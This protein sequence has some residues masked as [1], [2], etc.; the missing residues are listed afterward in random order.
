[1]QRI[2]C[3]SQKGGVGKSTLARDIAVQFAA[4]QWEVRIADMDDRQTTS[5]VWQANRAQFG[6]KPEVHVY[7]CAT[8]ETAL[9]VGGCD[10]VVFDGKPYSSPDTRKIA[11]VSDL[12]VIPSGP[13]RDD[14]D[15]QILLAHELTKVRIPT[16]RILFVI[17][18]IVSE[19]DG[20]EATSAR[21]YVETAGY[22]VA[23]FMLPR[24]ASYGQAHNIGKSISEVTA[25]SLRAQ[26]IG[27]VSEIGNIIK[28][29]QE[30]A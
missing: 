17:N 12:I 21:Q 5:M 22:R 28:E 19:L 29:A 16:S 11:E 20:L 4:N 27:V 18:S 9:K 15:P 1:M 6:H 8:P 23:Q 13:T 25:P 30:A 3:V 26:A 24:R 2:A 10:L 7:G 14:L